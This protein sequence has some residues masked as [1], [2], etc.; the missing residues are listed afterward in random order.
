[1]KLAFCLNFHVIIIFFFSLNKLSFAGCVHLLF[2]YLVDGIV[3]SLFGTFG[4]FFVA[5]S[6]N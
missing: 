1:M 6:K 2:F 3:M 5:I 4:L